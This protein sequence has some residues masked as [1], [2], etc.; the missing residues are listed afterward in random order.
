MMSKPLIYLAG[1][2][3]GTSVTP[4][5]DWRVDCAKRFAPAI[6]T[7][8]PARQAMETI[9]ES[10]EPTDAQ[11]L[12]L[13]VH[14]RG[15][16]ARDRLDVMRCDLVLVNL[17]GAPRIS[18]GSVGEIFWADAF[19]KPVVL[20]REPGNVHTH[21]MLDALVGWIVPE[22]DEAIE[23]AKTLILPSS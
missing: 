8:S 9:D 21:A 20:V 11:R 18:I 3:T 23:L 1:P 16:A 6:D 15:V 22:L 12:R 7:L 5:Q 14:G 10:G 4:G 2:I 17:V 19:R 13:I